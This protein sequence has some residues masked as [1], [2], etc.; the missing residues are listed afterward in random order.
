MIQLL[1]REITVSNRHSDLAF[2]RWI[3]KPMLE[4]STSGKL[5]STEQKLQRCLFLLVLV[6]DY[7][8]TLME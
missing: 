1:A 5:L 4:Y 7:S 2:P 3:Y 6:N 8:P